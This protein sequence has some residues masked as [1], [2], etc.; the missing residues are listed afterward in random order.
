V[1]DIRAIECLDDPPLAHDPVVATRR[2]GRRWDAQRPV[3]VTATDLVDLVLRTARD[4]AVLDRLALP[5]ESLSVHP[6]GESIDV[7]HEV[8]S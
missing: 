2:R 4:V 5:G 7:D 8:L 1:R 6:F 3:E